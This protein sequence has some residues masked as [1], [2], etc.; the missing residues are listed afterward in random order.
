MMAD[1][2]DTDTKEQPKQEV[3][4]KPEEQEN[5]NIEETQS[6][7]AA[8]ARTFTEKGRIYS[9]QQMEKSFSSLKSLCTR[10]TVMVNNREPEE[11]ISQ[12]YRDWM[13]SYEDFLDRHYSHSRKLNQTDLSD[14]LKTYDERETYLQNFKTALQ[15]YFASQAKIKEQQSKSLPEDGQ[16]NRS[17]G[18][19][20]YSTVS[21]VSS[22]KLAEE[23]KRAELEAKKESL[24]KKKE[25]ELAKVAL[26]M[27]EEK[28]EIETNIAMAKAKTKV[29]DKF[30]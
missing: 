8:R 3:D 15:D 6:E 11:R 16:D 21:A 23:E 26:K 9:E 30:E 4:E 20:Q 5:G 17:F 7:P 22:R 13:E 10:I 12:K 19:G 25:I 18:R 28:L 2:Q 1:K 24:K 27:E 14:Y 29:F